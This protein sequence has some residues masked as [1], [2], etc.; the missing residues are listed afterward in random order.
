MELTAQ[1]GWIIILAIPVACITWTVTHE[2]ILREARELL[3]ERS[4]RAR[5]VFG[6]KFHHLFTCEYCFSHYVSLAFVLLTGFTALQNDWRG[7]LISWLAV[8]WVANI[9]MSLYGRL[10]L[11]LKKERAEIE[12]RRKSPPPD[13]VDSQQAKRASAFPRH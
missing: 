13:S 12:E 8:V 11:D 9:Y 4:R 7:Y 1:F 2:E 3:I 6:K 5:T 10:R